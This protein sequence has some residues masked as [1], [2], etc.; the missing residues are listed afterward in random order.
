MKYLPIKSTL[1]SD[2]RKSFQSHMQK[3]SL[4]ILNSSDEFPRSGDQNFIF[5][6]NADI[7]YLSGIDQEQT[8]LLLFPDS[9]N[10]K[11]REILFLR[12]TNEHI[13]VWEGH[14]Y[15]REDAAAT[16]GIPLNQIFWL[17]DFEN[18]LPTC[19]HYAQ[20][21]YL[22]TNENDRY[23]HQTDYRD[24][25]FI[26]QLRERYPL[27]TFLRAA[28]ILSDLRMYKSQAEILLTEKAISITGNAFERI[29][30]FLKP[31]I[32]EFEL[33]AEIIHEFTR[34]RASGHAYNPIIASGA[35]AC[36]LHYNENNRVCADG[37]LVLMDFGAEYANYNADMS[38]TVPV[39]GRFS[40]RQREV[41]EAVLRIFKEARTLLVPGKLLEDYRRETDQLA[42]NEIYALGLIRKSDLGIQKPGA[43]FR[44]FY[45]HGIS[46]FLGLDVHDVGNRYTVLEPGMLLTCEP[47][48]YIPA[49][50]MGIRLENNIL[51]T[52]NGNID[53]MGG[54]PMEIDEIEDMMN[55]Q[56]LIIR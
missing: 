54:I 24:L 2:N 46:H 15:T 18:I 11:Y 3:N 21:I 9:P 29:L 34:S 4:C 47:G 48:I 20:Q 45:P 31:G 37:D 38:R 52:E 49:E 10:P 36:I 25:R 32:F 40:P 17:K 56:D 8:I 53:L 30:G 33:E 39:N 6:Q 16:S 7:F 27:H 43:A 13:A 12:E 51:V 35:Q 41:Y 23:V 44:K 5:K 19:M 28:P 42:E 1:F 26:R 22:N 50:S 55:S 14:K